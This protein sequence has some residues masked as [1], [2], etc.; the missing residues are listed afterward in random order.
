MI[1]DRFVD[2]LLREIPV[3][4]KKLM[5]GAMS[6]FIGEIRHHAAVFEGVLHRISSHYARCVT[7]LA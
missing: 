5:V 3:N 1:V 4:P 6:L 7:Q 2:R